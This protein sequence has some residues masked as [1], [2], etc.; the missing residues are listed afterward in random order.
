[1]TE[2]PTLALTMGDVAGIGPEIIA[3]A[4]AR[5]DVF[6][7][8]RVVVI[9]DEQA[10]RRG[11][12]ATHEVLDVRRIHAIDEIVDEFG[13]INIVQPGET[14]YAPIGELSAAAGGAS[15]DFVR[16]ATRLARLGLVDGIVTAPL[17]K[18]AMHLAGHTY[19]G[20]TELLADEFGV[21]Q[22]SLVLAAEDLAVF[23]ITT[24]VSLRQACDLITVERT[25]E[26]IRL[27]NAFAMASGDG[28]TPI[29]VAGLNPHAG[30]GG[31]FG[32]EDVDI[33]APAVA[34]A[35]AEGIDARGPLPADALVPQAVAGKW[36]YIVVAYHDQGHVPF[37]SVYGDSG[38]NITAGLPV[39][40]VS[41]DHGTA[42]D[43]AGMG[44]ARDTSLVLAITRAAQLAPGWAHIWGGPVAAT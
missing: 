38:V 25:L 12:A 17:N 32:R 36:K 22:F 41:V 24:H 10:L 11:M 8:A 2:R 3:K 4:M 39:V 21:K 1:M 28:G 30:E 37:K 14:V 7:V 16:E 34:L 42:F 35:I 5:P 26:T 31:I 6:D 15:V 9:G 27:A 33:M 44:V 23:H 19:P 20:H 43:I 29:G 40:R 13:V 18:A